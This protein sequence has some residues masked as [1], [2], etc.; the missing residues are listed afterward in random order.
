MKILIL[1]RKFAKV[2]LYSRSRT[3]FILTNFRPNF[4][5]FLQTIAAKEVI[6][7]DTQKIEK[8]NEVVDKNTEKLKKENERLQEHTKN[9]CRCWIWLL[10]MIVTFTFIAMVWIMKFFR[11]RSDY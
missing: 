6:Q 10:L 4:F 8:A 3:P 1:H 9:S 2:C 5:Y 7:K 11:K